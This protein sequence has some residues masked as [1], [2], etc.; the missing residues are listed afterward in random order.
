MVL[1][2]PIQAINELRILT[3]CSISDGKLWVNNLREEIW[4]ETL[5]LC[6]FCGEKLRIPLA[7][8]CRHCLCDWHDKANV[9][10][11]G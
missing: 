11:L 9:K 8:Q 3:G 2:K 5:P 10:I 4:Y 1:E 6:L 7:K